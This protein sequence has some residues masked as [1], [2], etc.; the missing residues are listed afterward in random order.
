MMTP[1][2]TDPERVRAFSQLLKAYLEVTGRSMS[3]LHTQLER[4]GSSWRDREFARFVQEIRK[5]ESQLS[6][7]RAEITKIAPTLD[8]YARAADE[9]H[10]EKLGG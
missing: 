5:I 9:I 6:V 4:L 3:T 1:A 10:S 7:L 2:H 8:T